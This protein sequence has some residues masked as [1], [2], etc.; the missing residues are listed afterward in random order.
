MGRLQLTCFR[1]QALSPTTAARP[2]T[3][4]PY[5]LTSTIE[6][7]I[8]VEDSALAEKVGAHDRHDSA[9]HDHGRGQAENPGEHGLAAAA[10]CIGGPRRH[11]GRGVAPPEQRHIPPR[12]P[13]AHSYHSM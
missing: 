12:P 5:S 3:L 7:K 11:L 2:A 10:P 9:G 6:V 4:V 8:S 1:G 13:A